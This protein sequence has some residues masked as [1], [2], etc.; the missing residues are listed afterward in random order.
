MSRQTPS[1]NH[2]LPILSVDLIEDRF[3]FTSTITAGAAAPDRLERAGSHVRGRRDPFGRMVM[4]RAPHLAEQA[5]LI[6]NRRIL[7]G[8]RRDAG[9]YREAIR[10]PL[11]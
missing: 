6:N 1:F 9:L 8:R 2:A 5:G 7:L 4:E 11:D 10:V 3:R